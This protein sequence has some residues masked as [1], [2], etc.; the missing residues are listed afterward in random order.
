MG[1]KQFYR[2]CKKH[3]LNQFDKKYLTLIIMDSIWNCTFV[4]TKYTIIYIICKGCTPCTKIWTSILYQTFE[5]RI[6]V[7]EIDDQCFDYF[8]SKTESIVYHLYNEYN[9]SVAL[10]EEK[11]ELKEKHQTIS[12]AI[13]LTSKAIENQQTKR[14]DH[15]S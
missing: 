10:Q 3:I 11:I 4:C 1:L 14:S 12:I 5:G 2:Q 8:C 13:N 7:K 6:Y 15:Y 9:K